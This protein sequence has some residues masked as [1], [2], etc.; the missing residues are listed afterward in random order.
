MSASDIAFCRDYDIAGLV[1]EPGFAAI[2]S[3]H[4]KLADRYPSE[5]GA[6]AA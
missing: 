6:E 1:G 2:Q 5:E 4:Q 3:L